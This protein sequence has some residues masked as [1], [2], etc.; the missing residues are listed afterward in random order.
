A[1]HPIVMTLLP[2]SPNDIHKAIELH[3]IGFLHLRQFQCRSHYILQKDILVQE[4]TLRDA[5]AY[6]H[7]RNT[8]TMIEHT[9]FSDQAVM[10]NSKSM[11]RTEKD[12][13]IVHFTAG[14]QGIKYSTDLFVHMA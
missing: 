10:P 7:H 2:L 9:L 8:Y 13:G 3:I 6:H 12:I 5:R 14:F 4:F 11:V 1:V